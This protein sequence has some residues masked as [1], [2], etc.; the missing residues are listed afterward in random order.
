MKSAVA[1]RSCIH[2]RFFQLPRKFIDYCIAQ[3][4]KGFLIEQVCGSGACL[5]K[6]GVVDLNVAQLPTRTLRMMRK[7]QKKCLRRSLQHGVSD[8]HA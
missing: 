8:V 4:A 6:P 5:L 7:Q 3:R 1:I 2:H